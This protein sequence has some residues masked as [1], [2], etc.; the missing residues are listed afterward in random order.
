VPNKTADLFVSCNVVCNHQTLWNDS[1]RGSSNYVVASET[2]V[3]NIT[4]YFGSH[5]PYKRRR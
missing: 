4:D 2:V 5:F 3:D 1:Y